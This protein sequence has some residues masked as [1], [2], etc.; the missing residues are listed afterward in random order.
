MLFPAP[1]PGDVVRIGKHANYRYTGRFALTMRVVKVC[2]EPMVAG[3]AWVQGY[4]LNSCGRAVAKRA[5][6][7]RIAG[8]VFVWT[9]EPRAERAAVGKPVILPSSYLT[10]GGVRLCAKC[11]RW[12]VRR[13]ADIF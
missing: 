9:P 12:R 6:L 3:L 5:I 11:N 7:V 1:R 13:A 10:R 2:D 8:L 4:V